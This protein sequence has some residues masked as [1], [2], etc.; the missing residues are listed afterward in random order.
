MIGRSIRSIGCAAAC[1]L[2]SAGALS[3]ADAP[4]EGMVRQGIVSLHYFEYEDANDAFRQ[5]QAVDPGIALAYWGEAMSYHQTLWRNENL[6]AARSALA[7]L[8]P[9]PAAR[10]AKAQSPKEKMLLAAADA[11]FG[12]GDAE[13][14]RRAYADAMGRLY[15]QEGDDPDVAS[16]YA[17]AL[18]GTM[19]RSLIG[20]VDSHEGHS[21]SLAGSPIQLRADAILEKVLKANPEH[22]GA[23]HYFLHAN[24]DPEHAPLALEAAQALARLAPPASHA[25]HMPAHIFLQ[26]GRWGDAARSDEASFRASDAWVVRRG[27]PQTLRNYHAL[28]W[29]Q[30]ERLQQGR[31]RD[32]RAALVEI[33]PVVKSSRQLTLLSDLSTMRAR[34]VIEAADWT[35]VAAADTFGN[36]NELFAIGMSAARMGDA[37]RAERV[38]QLLA[39]RQQ[40]EREGDLRPAIAIMER[41]V[42]ALIAARSDRLGEALTTM[43]A[44]AEA[45]RQLPPPLGLPA[46]IKPAPEL[47]GEL[48]LDAG[49]P[50]EA[51]QSFQQALERNPNRSLSVLGLARAAAARG[52]RAAAEKHY[53]QLL[54]NFADADPDL[55]LLREA[56]AAVYQPVNATPRSGERLDTRP[57]PRWIGLFASTGGLLIVALALGA[58]GL[59][60][61]VA[62]RSM[63]APVRH[64]D[65][66]GRRKKKGP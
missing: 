39:E 38:R 62:H 16:F 28:A 18:L 25:L 23:L 17:L 50:D 31:Y 45:E 15:E 30:Y 41:E 63:S 12:A 46:P 36:A 35:L 37:T 66:S 7:K 65:K 44:A 13:A 3:A 49:R 47:F 57:T 19:S 52:D 64:S 14:R 34:Y 56:R 6:E 53:R 1:A 4:A 24:D 54:A 26:L 21:A 61:F 48:L 5:A 22:P 11:L 51:A 58:I 33:E 9:T 32:A 42:A 55:P 10:A 43:S 60:W 2:A 20:Y 8:G 40:D 29:L 59:T 27:L